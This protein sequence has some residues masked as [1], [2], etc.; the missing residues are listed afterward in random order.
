MHS[1]KIRVGATRM[2]KPVTNIPANVPFLFFLKVTHIY[3]SRK[4]S[5]KKQKTEKKRSIRGMD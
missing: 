4:K 1:K 2:K 5:S 3:V